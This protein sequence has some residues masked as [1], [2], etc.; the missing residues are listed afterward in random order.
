[1]DTTYRYRAPNSKASITIKPW[2]FSSLA[3][4]WDDGNAQLPDVKK[5]LHAATYEACKEY[6]ATCAHTFPTPVVYPSRGTV[7]HAFD[8]R[9]VDKPHR[10]SPIACLELVSA[11]YALCL[12]DALENTLLALPLGDRFAHFTVSEMPPFKTLPRLPLQSI[13]SFTYGGSTAVWSNSPT[14]K[15]LS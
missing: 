3:H 11:Q 7:M 8:L 1:V 6:E 2:T 13:G 4:L 9:D 12:I 5:T 14:S 10:H 15:T